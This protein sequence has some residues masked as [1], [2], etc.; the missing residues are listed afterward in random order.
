MAG[1]GA[2]EDAGGMT[3]RGLAALA[4]E[5]RRRLLGGL[6]DREVAALVYDWRFW[7]RPEQL[8]PSGG[9]RIWLVLAGRGFGKTRTGAEWVRAQVEL[10]GRRT[11]AL[12]GPTMAAVRDVM[13]EGEAGLLAVAPPWNRPVYKPSLRR[14]DWPGGASAHVYSAEEPERLRGPNHDAAWADELA[15]WSRLEETWDMLELTLRAGADPRAVI[16]TT[17]K[18]QKRLKAI[19]A[20]SDTVVT[21]GSTYDNAG[22]LAPAFLA[23][24]LKRYEGTRLGRQELQAELLED[25]PGALWSWATIE[26]ARI[27]TVP[28]LARIVVAVDP[29][30]TA[31]PDADETGIIVVGR[32]EGGIAVVLADLSLRGSP[33]AWGQRVVEAH[34]GWRADRIVAE[35]NQGGDMVRHVIATVDPMAPFRAVHAARGKRAR[36]EPVAALYEQGRVRHAPGL[37][38]LEDQMCAFVPGVGA[39][40]DR[41]DALVWALSD[42][43]LDPATEPKVWTI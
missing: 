31:G 35:V 29:A 26:A 41:V 13:V 24:I 3:A 22:N 28:A 9:W 32:T 4:P 18:P 19:I 39:S 43:M 20:D 2:P 25:V 10:H 11:I 8:P 42:L 34:R 14:I 16:T 7:A 30:A 21:R 6:S 36:A 33:A 12:V 17:P 38:A 1:A 27:E 37:A 23:R 40:P 15:A 5:A